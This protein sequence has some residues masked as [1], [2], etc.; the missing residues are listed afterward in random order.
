MNQQITDSLEMYIRTD[1]FSLR[2]IC[3][4]WISN[5]YL[6]I[7]SLKNKELLALLHTLPYSFN[8][9]SKYFKLT[10][11]LLYLVG[12]NFNFIEGRLLFQGGENKVYEKLIIRF[13]KHFHIQ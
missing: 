3:Q 7:V 12:I 5:T 2:T 11:F 4:M 10:L 1:S 8:S 9:T 6:L 13:L